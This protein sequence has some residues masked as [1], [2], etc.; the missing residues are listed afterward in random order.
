M[1]RGFFLITLV[2]S[3]NWLN[4]KL[5]NLNLFITL[6]KWNGYDLETP[7]GYLARKD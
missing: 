1:S 3:N 5:E 7:G 4:E 6:L 2:R